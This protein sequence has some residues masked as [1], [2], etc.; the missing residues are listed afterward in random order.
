[1]LVSVQIPSQLV[2]ISPSMYQQCPVILKDHPYSSPNL[3]SCVYHYW[4]QVDSVKQLLYIRVGG[5]RNTKMVWILESTAVNESRQKHPC[6]LAP[7][8]SG[9]TSLHSTLGGELIPPS[10]HIGTSPSS[11]ITPIHL[12]V[13][14]FSVLYIILGTHPRISSIVWILYLGIF[15]L[16]W[17]ICTMP[18]L[19]YYPI[20]RVSPYLAIQHPFYLK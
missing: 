19:L 18:H 11:Y 13:P 5:G 6:A 17:R 4:G 8:L 3:I 10:L 20:P 7:Q 16:I 12:S 14:P 15:L 2:P 9:S 1:M